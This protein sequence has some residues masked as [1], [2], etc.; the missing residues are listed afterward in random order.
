MRREEVTSHRGI[1]AKMG[2]AG[3][4]MTVGYSHLDES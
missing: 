1:C 4:E 3:V 2:P